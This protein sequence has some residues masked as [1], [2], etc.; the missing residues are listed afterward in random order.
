MQ[1]ASDVLEKFR[2]EDYSTHYLEFMDPH[3]CY[4]W[5]IQG[6]F[7]FLPA[8]SCL[9]VGTQAAIVF[10]GYNVNTNLPYFAVYNVHFFC[11]NF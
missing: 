5:E 6:K 1:A 9:A 10:Q 11:P 2:W 3:K 8:I 4:C 7:E